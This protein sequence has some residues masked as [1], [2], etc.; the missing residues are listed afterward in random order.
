MMPPPSGHRA[1]EEL[2]QV[3]GGPLDIVQAEV[4]DRTRARVGPLMRSY[5]RTRW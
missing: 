5:E 3:G 4:H 2:H 1:Q